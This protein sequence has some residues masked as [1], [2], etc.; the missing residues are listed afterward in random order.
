MT[1]AAW[2]W[3]VIVSGNDVTFYKSDPFL[4]TAQ[5]GGREPGA[6]VMRVD[7]ENQP[8][9]HRSEVAVSRRRRRRSVSESAR[10]RVSLNDD[11]DKSFEARQAGNLD[12]GA[13]WFELL[14]DCKI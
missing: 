6:F 4:C 13:E 14:H 10:Q 11:D 1:T 8:R 2:R 7:Y 9:P 3:R 12:R 5:V